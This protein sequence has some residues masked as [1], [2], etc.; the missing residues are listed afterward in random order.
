MIKAVELRKGR[1]V[2]YQDTLY[3]V[4]EAAH[5]AK[6]NKRSYMQ[7]KLKPVQQGLLL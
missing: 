3:V 5:V 7:V 2:L 6:G 4:H 1:T